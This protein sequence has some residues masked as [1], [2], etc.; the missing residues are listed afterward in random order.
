MIFY[1]DYQ[2]KK[3]GIINASGQVVSEPIYDGHGFYRS[4]VISVKRG[5]KYALMNNK[6]VLL[7]DFE[8]DCI[9]SF[10]DGTADIRIG[11]KKGIMNVQG[12]HI[13]K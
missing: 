7:T 5:D 1:Y 11:D 8:F 3:Y 6:G 10:I 13:I 2:L 9:S 4:K 12:D